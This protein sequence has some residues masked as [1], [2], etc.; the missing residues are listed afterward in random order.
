MALENSDP[1]LNGFIWRC[2]PPPDLTSWLDEQVS[3]AVLEYVETGF[4][5]ISGEKLF[6]QTSDPLDI[7]T[8]GD[9][10]SALMWDVQAHREKDGKI[11]DAAVRESILRLRAVLTDAIAQIDEGLTL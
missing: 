5:Y 2:K 4:F 9:L 8:E 11:R 7:V 3:A 6:F 1:D 10:F